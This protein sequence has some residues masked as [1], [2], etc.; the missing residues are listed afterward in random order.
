[1]GINFY[2]LLSKHVIYY[3][4]FTCLLKLYLENFLSQRLVDHDLIYN[5]KEKHF[6]FSI[7]LNK[8]CPIKI[9]GK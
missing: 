8:C 6:E 2:V 4:V 9:T 1:M 5:L 7:V 3:L